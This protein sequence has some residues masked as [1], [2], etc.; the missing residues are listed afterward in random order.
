MEVDLLIRNG[1]VVTENGMVN[2]DLAILGEKIV[3]MGYIN[4]AIS[5]IRE[6]DAKDLIIL[7]GLV[8]HHVHFREP[9][10]TNEEDFYT[11][12][13]AAAAG[14]VTTVFEQPVDSP[15]TTTVDRFNEKIEIGSAKSCVDFGLWGGI[16]PDNLDQIDGLAKSG[17]CAFKAFVCSSDPAYPMVD[18]GV[19]L[20]AMNRIRAVGKMIAVHAEDQAIIEHFTSLL[21][22]STKVKGSNYVNSRPVVSEIIA[23]QR[24]IVLA[25]QAKVHLHILHLSSS[26]GA[27][28][29][30]KAKQDRQPI[31]V[32]TCPHYL[33]LDDRSMDK[34]GPYAKCNPPLRDHENQK[35]LWQY[36]REGIID[37][38]V[39]DHSPYTSEDKAKGLED[40]RFA[41]PGINA[42]EL[43]LPLMVNEV[44]RRDEITFTDL[45][46]WMSTN[47]AKLMNV[48]PKKGCIDIGSDADLVII[49]PHRIWEVVPESLETK[50]K[51]SPFAGWKLQ[52]RVV[53][54]IIRG[55]TVY[56]EGK[57]LTKPGFGKFINPNN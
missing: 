27:L 21:N 44:L 15:P 19:M 23:I 46:V 56:H 37:C 33:I 28:L 47:P 13:R 49:D 5:A 52:G 35:R 17:A 14:G 32:E 53:E 22:Q 11:G 20:E 51:W 45:A 7:P 10:P 40:I 43:A 1:I 3:A 54:T 55:T 30:D 6:F 8:D 36:L 39:S 50:N 18:D 34:Y 4:G 9:G 31:T 41:P 24:M 57:I 42:L 26:E 2:I 16:V 48:Y 29:I 25:K 38:L 12:S